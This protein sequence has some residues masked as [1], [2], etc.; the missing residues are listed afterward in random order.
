VVILSR[1]VS[2]AKDGGPRIEYRPG[3]VVAFRDGKIIHVQPYSSH[4]E[5]LQ[6]V[7]RRE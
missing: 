6:A 5:A 1:T 7:G 4:T 3:Y 2:V